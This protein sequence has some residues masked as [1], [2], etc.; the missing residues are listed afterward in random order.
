MFTDYVS[1]GITPR[2]DDKTSLLDN[3]LGWDKIKIF[4]PFVS[5]VDALLLLDILWK[6]RKEFL[7][8][9]LD[10]RAPGLTA[11]LFV[12]WRVVHLN[13]YVLV[14]LYAQISRLKRHRHKQSR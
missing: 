2:L 7:R 6:G 8:A 13:G 10:T 4:P 5:Q 11:L 1:G 12:L 14:P 3:F 9:W